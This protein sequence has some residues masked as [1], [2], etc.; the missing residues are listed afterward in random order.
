MHTGI[1]CQCQF[2]GADKSDKQQREITDSGDKSKNRTKNK[3]VQTTITNIPSYLLNLWSLARHQ[4][5]AIPQHNERDFSAEKPWREKIK[6]SRSS[7][8]DFSGERASE[9]TQEKQNVIPR[10]ICRNWEHW[11]HV[12][13]RFCDKRRNAPF[14]FRKCPLLLREKNALEVST[15]PPGMRCFLRHYFK[16]SNTITLHIDGSLLSL[17]L[18]IHIVSIS[19]SLRYFEIVLKNT[20]SV[21]DT[22]IRQFF[23]VSWVRLPRVCQFGS[24]SEP[25]YRWTASQTQAQ[26]VLPNFQYGGR[27]MPLFP[28]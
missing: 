19:T 2:G 28:C 6:R 15:P 10:H 8:P 13:P 17:L 3:R 1:F 20:K 9:C 22:S 4:L 26:G 24:H 23:G 18:Y 25:R 16:R 7:P 11:G 21:H 14:I 5:P 27:S 12:P